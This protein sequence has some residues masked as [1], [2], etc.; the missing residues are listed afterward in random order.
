MVRPNDV[1]ISLQPRDDATEAMV[2]RVVHLGF[3]VRVELTLSDGGRA[4]AQLTRAQ[5]E[6]LELTRGDIVYVRS[7]VAAPAPV[8]A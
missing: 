4:R 3:E 8:T 6:E 5:T 1:T 2:S 7:P